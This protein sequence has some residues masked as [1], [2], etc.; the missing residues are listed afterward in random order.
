[1]RYSAH[2][3]NELLRQH[4]RTGKLLHDLDDATETGDARELQRAWTGFEK[5][6]SSHL[7]T[8]ERELF[9]LVEDFHLGSLR[10]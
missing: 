4:E 8:E 3:R 6:L 2:L 9:P 1:M 10:P 5:E 7:E